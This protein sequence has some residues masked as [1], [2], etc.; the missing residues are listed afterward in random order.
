MS[1]PPNITTITPPRVPLVDPRTGIISRE[2]YRF[3]LNLFTLTYE[4]TGGSTNDFAL[5][6]LPVDYS[7]VIDT[8]INGLEV[9]PAPVDYTA[10]INAVKLDAEIGTQPPVIFGTLAYQNSENAFVTRLNTVSATTGARNGTLAEDSGFITM[11]GTNGAI[12][13]IGTTAVTVTQATGFR[14]FASNTYN[15]GT[16]GQRWAS[17][18]STEFLA[19]AGQ[20]A[21]FKE[22]S[23]F[24]VVD[25]DNGVTTG[26]AGTAVTVTQA[27]GFRPFASNTYN[28]GT[29]GQRWAS[30]YSTEFLAGS[31]QQARFKEDSDFAVVDGD[32]G[33]TTGIGGSVVTVTQASG[34]RPNASY[35]YNLGTSSQRWNSAY[36]QEF[37]AGDSQQAQYKESSGYALVNGSNG[38][39]TAYNS[40]V[41]T[42]VNNVGLRPNVSASY[43]LGTSSYYWTG[44]YGSVFYADNTTT[45]FYQ[46]TDYAVLTGSNGV[47][48]AIGTTAITVTQATGFRPNVDN[49]YNLGTS[50]QRWNT[51]Y[52]SV[53]TINTSDGNE[54]QQ[55]QE[56]TDVERRVAQRLKTLVRT[57]K[58]NS[59]VALKGDAARTHV[60]VIAQDV[61][62]AFAAEGLDAHKYGMFCSDDIE[63]AD[64]TATTRL[65]VRYDQLLTFALAAL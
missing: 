49:T 33:V 6:P 62:A 59:A 46:D 29:S 43:S 41:I 56:L 11:L 21:R 27:T 28:L 13:G 10:E 39:R 8:T 37:L 57:F 61:R 14:P 30:T 20:Q 22:D 23:G 1:S 31:A 45:K 4:N 9:A 36:A 17:T 35:S 54:K 7:D 47:I 18:Y 15:L 16:S 65:G 19:G 50:G 48:T 53:G 52:A 40:T 26:I 42:E 55:I 63:S 34:F 38:V 2:W 58:W 44:V 60:G 5:A 12:T 32:N 3:F 64:G 24:A 51:V 25:G